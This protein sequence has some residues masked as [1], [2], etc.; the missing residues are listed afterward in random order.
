MLELVPRSVCA[1][2]ARPAVVCLCASIRRVPT[3]TRVVILQHP[4]ERDV[5]INT[6][7]LVELQL[8][9]AERHVGIKLSE[10]PALRARLSDPAAP[11]ILLYPSEGSRDLAQHPPPGPVTLCV[12]D[13]TWWQAKK[14]FQQNPELAALPRYALAPS[15]PSRYRIRREPE[16]HCV[17]TIEAIGQALELLEQGDFDREALLRPFE[18]MVEH[19]LAYATQGSARH[20]AAR[21]RPKRSH[22]A[23]GLL[24]QAERLVVGYGEAN[25]WPKATELGGEAEVVHWVAERVVDGARF[26]A[27]IAPRRPLSPAFPLHSKLP[28]ELVV[29]GE[30]FASF[31]ARWQAFMRPDDVLLGWGFFA[32]ERL[33]SEGVPLPERLDLRPLA[34]R[35]LRHTTGDVAACATAL[36]AAQDPAWA[37]GRAGERLAGA[38]AVTRA[39]LASARAS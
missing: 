34:R 7:K 3:R 37:H 10:L 19:Q 30:S 26:E 21:G 20:L 39:L 17:S 1:G 28:A 27:L 24:E 15:A 18:A 8:E 38:L 9:R 4:R 5:P 35:Q 22:V 14:L 32:S 2:C 13:G 36:G 29:S 33:A 12:L 6:A 11:A 23:R 16:L 31:S 25:A